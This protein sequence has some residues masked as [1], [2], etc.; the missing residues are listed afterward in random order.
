MLAP[1]LLALVVPSLF[2]VGAIELRGA[3]SIEKQWKSAVSKA[4]ERTLT[5]VILQILRDNTKE[6]YQVLIDQGMASDDP[7]VEGVVERALPNRMAEGPGFDHLCEQA[8]DHELAAVRL[9]IVRAFAVRPEVSARR[10]QLRALYDRDPAVI[11]ESLEGLTRRNKLESVSYVIDALVHHEKEGRG[12]S[13]FAFKMREFLLK[14]TG[15]WFETGLEYRSFWRLHSQDYTAPGKRKGTG[16][17]TGTGVKQPKRQWPQFFGVEIVA[18]KIVFVLDVSSSMRDTGGHSETRLARLKKE[19]DRMIDSLPPETE[20]TV[21]CFNSKVTK[22]SG[23]LLPATS[24][25]KSR[26]KSFFA[27]TEPAAE[28]WTDRALEAAF[29]VPNVRTIFLLSDGGPV[30]DQKVIHVPDILDWI[31][32]TNRFRKIPIHCVGFEGTEQSIGHFLRE[33][34]RLTNGQYREI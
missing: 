18:Q 12:A 24:G 26:A 17:N 16:R 23:S 20:F 13:F 22:L 25:N 9:Q 1:R 14:L 31:V 27:R 15:E 11:L 3:E 10:A 21:I 8:T 34:A 5:G 19:L 28:T 4:D 7:W 32:K 33:A 2:L 29:A 30:R 6:G